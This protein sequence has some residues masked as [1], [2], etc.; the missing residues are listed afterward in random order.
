MDGCR[1]GWVVAAISGEADLRLWTIGDA[2]LRPALGGMVRA[3]V[4]IDIPIGLPDGGAR[5]ADVE[6]R[7][8]LGAR[9]AS[10]FPAPIRPVLDARSWEEACAISRG[11][12]GAGCSRQTVGILPKVRAVDRVMTPD[13]QRRV[14][15]G[16]P[17]VSFATMAGG[18]LRHPKRSEAGRRER[19]TLLR[20]RFPRAEALLSRLPGGVSGDGI[21]A[22]AMLW[23]ALRLRSGQAQRLPAG[24]TEVDGR[25]LR[26]EIAF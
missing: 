7:R 2:E 13:L 17:E 23:T 10:V 8:R 20:A 22:L 1:R 3:T 24:V 25:G 21:D 18:P 5:R 14:A 26:C 4:V 15:E 9:R 12:S 6:A 19:L 16:H 11:V